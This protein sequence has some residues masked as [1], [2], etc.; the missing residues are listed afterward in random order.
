MVHELIFL[1]YSTNESWN[2][3]LLGAL[4]QDGGGLII[5]R[6][7]G[8]EMKRSMPNRQYQHSVDY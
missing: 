3:T 2:E 1:P 5:T 6:R 7:F 4:R 8:F